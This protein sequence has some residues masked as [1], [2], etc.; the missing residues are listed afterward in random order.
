MWLSDQLAKVDLQLMQQMELILVEIKEE[1][2][3]LIYKA[4]E[5]ILQMY[6]EVICL[7]LLVEKIIKLILHGQLLLVVNQI[8]LQKFMAQF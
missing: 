2:I 6:Q 4:K 3:Q 5:V 7:L 8:Q 1:K